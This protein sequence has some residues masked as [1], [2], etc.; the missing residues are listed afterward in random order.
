VGSR[1]DVRE[2][3]SFLSALDRSPGSERTQL[4][5]QPAHRI[6][7][8]TRADITRTLRAVV[9]G[10]VVGRQPYYSRNPPIEAR[11]IKAY[12]LC[13]LAVMKDISHVTLTVGMTNAFDIYHESPY[14][15]P[16]QGRSVYVA[17]H[18]RAGG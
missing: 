10:T 13:D 8:E 6:A 4:Q 18:A 11:T 1:V 12:T 14:G 3:Y 2:I 5:Y 17:L 7:V 9:T 16:N 15:M